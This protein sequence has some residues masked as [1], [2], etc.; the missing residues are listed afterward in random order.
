LTGLGSIGSRHL[1]LLRERPEITD[2]I[3]Y[4]RKITGDVPG[5]SEFDDLDEALATDPDIAFVTNPTHLHVDTATQ[6]A[7]TGCHLFVEKPLSHTRKGVDRL[8]DVVDTTGVVTMVGCQLRFTPIFERLHDT[9]ATQRY[10][11]VLSFEAYSG[12]YLPDWRPDQD[13]RESYSAD[14]AKGGGVVLDLIHE[15][16]YSHW[17]FGPFDDVCGRVGKVSSLDIDSEDIAVMT[18]TGP[19][20]VGTVHLDYCRPTP[21]RTLEV[22]CE[23]GVLTAD[24]IDRTL[25]IDTADGTRTQ[26]FDYSR[27]DVFE[28]ELDHFFAAV[29]GD[30][31]VRNSV[32]E[33]K[34]VLKLAL[35]AKSS[36]E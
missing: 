33:A 8:C 7:R 27:D 20:I 11:P 35:D 19:S 13:Y 16:D 15:L 25:T 3:A 28:R 18:V 21:R 36:H 34:E 23:D 31:P 22:V 10:G 17:L 12:S 6:C 9:L 32:H 29:R 2:F 26:R 1:R 24:L 14:P 30:E 5:V 4:R